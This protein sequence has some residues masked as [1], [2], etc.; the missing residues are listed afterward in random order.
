LRGVHLRPLLLK[1]YPVEFA[2]AA[3]RAGMLPA[4]FLDSLAQRH[5]GPPIAPAAGQ[6]RVA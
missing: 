5:V 1:G 3:A 4:V 2:A 6:A